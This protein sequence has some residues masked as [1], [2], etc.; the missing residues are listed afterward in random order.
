MIMEPR[1]KVWTGNRFGVI[2]IEII[3][4]TSEVFWSVRVGVQSEKLRAEP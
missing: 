4:H 1:R 3:F 2:S